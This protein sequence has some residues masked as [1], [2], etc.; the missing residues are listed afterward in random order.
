MYYISNIDYQ[1]HNTNDVNHRII[2]WGNWVEVSI[3][4][5]EGSEIDSCVSYNKIEELINNLDS[6]RTSIPITQW[7][8]HKRHCTK[9]NCKYSDEDCPVLLGIVKSD[10]KETND[11]PF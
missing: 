4:D 9:D 6:E 2:D 10:I 3:L 7:G 11:Y 5:N 8:V 1:I